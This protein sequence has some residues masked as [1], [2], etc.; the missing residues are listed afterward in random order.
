MKS[1]ESDIEKQQAELARVE[2][3]LAD[4][5]TYNRLRAQEVSSLL[6]SSGR[7]RQEMA[8]LEDTWL[9]VSRLLEKEEE[10]I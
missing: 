7:L 10:G 4:K 5:E 8:Q 6:E 1:I 2:G 9:N 3:L